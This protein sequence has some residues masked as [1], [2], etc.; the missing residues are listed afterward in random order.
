MAKII[1]SVDCPEVK[2]PAGAVLFEEGAT[3]NCFYIVKAG[4]VDV[5]RNHGKV[6]QFLLATLGVGRVL[7][8][9]SCLDDGPRTAT[10]V[11]REDVQLVCVSAKT[12]K[13]QLAQLCQPS[14]ARR[15]DV[16]TVVPAGR[17]KLP[18]E[19]KNISAPTL[20]SSPNEPD[21]GTKAVCTTLTTASVVR[22]TIET[23]P[24]T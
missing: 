11:A 16:D 23:F 18:R 9:I 13:W 5:F 3:S 19:E 21:G 22:S 7:G 1:K 8:E 24:E 6:D 14:F 20:N 2:H 4:Q 12:L 10:A 15:W 17:L